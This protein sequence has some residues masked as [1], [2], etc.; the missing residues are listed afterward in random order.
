MAVIMIVMDGRLTDAIADKSTTSRACMSNAPASSKL[1]TGAVAHGT[2]RLKAF[3]HHRKLR[4]L[5]RLLAGFLDFGASAATAATPAL[6][7]LVRHDATSKW[8]A[9]SG[10]HTSFCTCECFS[11]G[12]SAFTLSL[13]ASK[14][15]MYKA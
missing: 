2:H 15:A 3:T 5:L 10:V 6:S 11:L 7:G 14:K 4:L 1:T 8:S 13:S 9:C 12:F